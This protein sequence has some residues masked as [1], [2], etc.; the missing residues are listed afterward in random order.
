MIMAGDQIYADCFHRR[1]PRAVPASSAADFLTAYRKSFGQTHLRRLMA[2]LPSYM[3]LEDHEILN[4]WSR[5]LLASG[6][7]NAALYENALASYRI[8]QQSHNP[9]AP[10]AA[11]PGAGASDA[12]EQFWYSFEWG[13]LPF[14]VMDVRG[15]RVRAGP[16]KTMLG[17][18]QL[19][20]FRAWLQAH[21]DKARLFVVSGVALFPDHNLWLAKS[22]KD[23]WYGFDEERG[24]LLEAIRATG[25]NPVIFLSGD[26]HNSHFAALRCREDDSFRAYSL[27]SS[28]FHA[29]RFGPL[30]SHT[31]RYQYVARKTLR[32]DRPAAA[33]STAAV[34]YA[35]EAEGFTAKDNFVVVEGELDATPPVFSARIYGRDGTPLGNLPDGYR[36]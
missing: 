33:G 17:A 12:D 6:D 26:I 35:Y 28:P 9:P 25:T 27:V 20:A 23:K 19:A 8:Y 1:L 15:A 5:D 29:W 36:C 14:F 22:R 24:A 31:H 3:I 11:T 32:Y 34:H 2:R 18:A 21:R 13:G 4:N 16:D 7:G 10:G 30:S